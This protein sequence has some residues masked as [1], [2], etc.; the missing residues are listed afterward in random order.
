VIVIPV[1]HFFVCFGF[2]IIVVSLYH[3]PNKKSVVK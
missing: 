2:P 1:I 3:V